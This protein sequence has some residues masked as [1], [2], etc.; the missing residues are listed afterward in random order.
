MSLAEIKS[1]VEALAPSELEELIAFI[2][3]HDNAAWDRE[4]ERGATCR[5][6]FEPTATEV[7]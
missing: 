2:R 1:A 7:S 3:E 6:E 4:I 5:V